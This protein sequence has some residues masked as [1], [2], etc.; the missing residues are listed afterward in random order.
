MEAA[1]HGGPPPHRDLCAPRKVGPG[2]GVTSLS[3]AL[4]AASSLFASSPLETGRPE[5]GIGRR[6]FPALEGGTIQSTLPV[7]VASLSIHAAHGA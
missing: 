5:Y 2:G 6:V 7:A 1:K 4:A 3:L